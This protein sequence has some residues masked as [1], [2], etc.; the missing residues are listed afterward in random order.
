V[1]GAR[2]AWRKSAR[3]QERKSARAQERKSARAQERKSARVQECKSASARVSSHMCTLSSQEVYIY[4][5]CFFSLPSSHLFFAQGNKGILIYASS[6]LEFEYFGMLLLLSF[7]TR[8]DNSDYKGVLLNELDKRIPTR[9][10][11]SLSSVSTDVRAQVI[12]FYDF[13]NTS[14]LTFKKNHTKN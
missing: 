5:M 9:T 6:A 1:V 10:L 3:A 12:R 4:S 11:K 7:K 2:L 8:V 13:A 14:M